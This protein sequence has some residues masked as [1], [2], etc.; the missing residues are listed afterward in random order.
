M[1]KAIA[2]DEDHLQQRVGL[3]LVET[4]LKAELNIWSSG[5]FT[6]IGALLMRKTASEDQ[7][8]IPEH[9]TITSN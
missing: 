5:H 2:V 3:N 6:P 9:G 8:K 4:L 1:G 7:V